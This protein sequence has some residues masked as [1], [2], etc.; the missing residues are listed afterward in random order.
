MFFV[1]KKKKIF[2][3]DMEKNV[4]LM[5]HFGISISAST[6]SFNRLHQIEINK[7]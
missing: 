5:I 7:H 1:K 3:R 4:N 2:L 6:P